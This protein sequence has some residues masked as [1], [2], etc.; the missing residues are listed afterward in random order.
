LIQISLFI[1]DPKLGCQPFF[2]LLTFIPA[3]SCTHTIH[4]TKII[5]NYSRYTRS[6]DLTICNMPPHTF[7]TQAAA[8]AARQLLETENNRPSGPLLPTSTIVILVCVGLVPVFL[9]IGIVIWLLAFYGRDKA[10]CPCCFRKRRGRKRAAKHTIG[11]PNGESTSSSEEIPMATLPPMTA[12]PARMM[13]DRAGYPMHV[14]MHSGGTG[15]SS[16]GVAREMRTF[17]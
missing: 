6:Y 4:F 2:V 14:R 9:T 3:P 15:S 11:S 1:Q 17:I 8:L 5:L 16:L 10:C 13:E 12:L 7:A